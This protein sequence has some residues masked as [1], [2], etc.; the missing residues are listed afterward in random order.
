MGKAA[1]DVGQFGPVSGG[2]SNGHFVD[3]CGNL[4]GDLA[5][6]KASGKISAAKDCN[7]LFDRLHRFDR[8]LSD[9]CRRGHAISLFVRYRAKPRPDV[10]LG[11]CHRSLCGQTHVRDGLRALPQGEPHFVPFRQPQVAR[12]E[13]RSQPG[14]HVTCRDGSGGFLGFCLDDV[15]FLARVPLAQ[16]R[17]VGPIGFRGLPHVFRRVVGSRSFVPIVLGRL[18]LVLCMFGG[19]AA[20]REWK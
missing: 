12:Q 18:F 14:R 4:C 3:A 5:V 11:A 13:S 20:G 10:Y 6:I 16:A 7:F 17:P 9:S 19:D 1:G 2:Q 15:P 8:S